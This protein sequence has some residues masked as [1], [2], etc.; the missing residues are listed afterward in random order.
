MNPTLKK[1]RES[2]DLSELTQSTFPDE[3]LEKMFSLVQ[4]HKETQLHWAAR[5]GTMQR[6][7]QGLSCLLATRIGV[8][9]FR[10]GLMFLPKFTPFPEELRL[11]R[12]AV[13][14]ESLEFL[15]KSFHGF[16]VLSLLRCDGFS[17][18]GI[19]SIAF[20]CKLIYLVNF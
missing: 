13:R 12:M 11:K 3:V 15:A 20:H 4:S 14:D 10:L 9:I 1:P 6:D 7:G 19:S 18:D 17:T 8:L 5:I 16:K 2:V